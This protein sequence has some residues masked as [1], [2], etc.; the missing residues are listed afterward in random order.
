MAEPKK[1]REQKDLL[2]QIEEMASGYQY[3]YGG[4]GQAVVN[5]NQR[6]LDL[7]GGN[8]AVKVTSFAG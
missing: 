2:D 8:T 1:T 5:A 7:R 4:C 6:E 3:Q